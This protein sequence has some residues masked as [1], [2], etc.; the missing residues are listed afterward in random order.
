MEIRSGREDDLVLLAEQRALGSALQRLGR[1]LLVGQGV[2]PGLAT[3]TV[4]TVLTSIRTWLESGTILSA[5]DAATLDQLEKWEE[6]LAADEAYLAAVRKEVRAGLSMT[7]RQ[8]NEQQGTASH[9]DHT[10]NG[11]TE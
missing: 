2:D 9:A 8:R 6:E 1:A 4:V 3:E 7:L 10:P 5:V 11:S